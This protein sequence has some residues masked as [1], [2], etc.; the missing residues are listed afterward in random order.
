M[1]RVVIDTNILYSYV[2]IS[3]N[4]R[5]CKTALSNFRLA[6]TTA[7]LIEVIVKYRNDL[8]KI[9]FCLTPVVKNEIELINIGHTPISNDKIYGIFNA[10]SISDISEVVEELFNLK[11]STE[12]EFLRFIM[13]ILFPGVVECLKRDGYGFSDVQKDNQQKVLVRCLLQ[14]YEESMLS[15]FKKQIILGYKE[16]DEQR[17]VFEAFREQFLSLLNIFHFNYHQISVG[18]LPEGDQSLDSEKE[19]ALVESISSDRLGKK[20]ERYIAN[21]VE[22]VTKKSNHALFD[23]Y[24]AV[25]ND[26]L[27]DLNSLNRSSLEYL[28]YTIES[29]FKNKSKIKKN[30]IFDLLISCSLGLEETRI[31][32]LD[33]GFLRMLNK[34]DTDSYN[35]C[36]S[37]G[38]MS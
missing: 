8:D 37:L 32:T 36:K 16:G 18:A 15:K 25:M 4:E 26:G 10:E 29:A 35:L 22:M 6:I 5:V 1:K 21:P 17:I 12:A 20:L 14:A 11:V 34:I 30:D 31:V 27:S 7:S 23:E 33:K 28:I 13:F 19:A 9:K 24:L 2:G 38:Y 3:E